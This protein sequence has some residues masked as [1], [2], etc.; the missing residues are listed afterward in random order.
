MLTL[1][2]LFKIVLDLKQY[3]ISKLFL[4]QEDVI[5]LVPN[6]NLNGYGYIIMIHVHVHKNIVED[7]LL[8]EGSRVKYKYKCTIRQA[9]SKLYMR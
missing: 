5:P 4:A 2:Q 6:L 9:C 7:V 3:V 8:D 1:G